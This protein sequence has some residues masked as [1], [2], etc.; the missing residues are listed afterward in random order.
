MGCAFAY[1]LHK[2]DLCDSMLRSRHTLAYMLLQFF[3]ND[4]F[5]MEF[6]ARTTENVADENKN[7]HTKANVGL[8]IK[9]LE[10]ATHA[11][12]EY[13]FSDTKP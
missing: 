6:L 1:L 4:H 3:K 7:G 9:R 11:M 12:A 2:A 5:Y 13:K 8:H 10:I